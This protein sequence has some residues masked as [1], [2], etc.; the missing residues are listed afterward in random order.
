MIIKY[1]LYFCTNLRHFESQGNGLIR[2]A[3]PTLSLCFSSLSSSLNFWAF[4]SLCK[5]DGS[6]RSLLK[7]EAD[8]EIDSPLLDETK[9]LAFSDISSVSLSGREGWA[10]TGGLEE[11]SVTWLSNC[12]PVFCSDASGPATAGSS[13]DPGVVSLCTSSCV[14]SSEGRCGD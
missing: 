4:A 10:L 1:F 14:L 8:A 7:D 6:L 13:E 11:M 5:S 9:V 3:E 12:L 2:E